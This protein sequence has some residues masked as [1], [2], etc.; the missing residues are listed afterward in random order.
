MRPALPALPI[1]AILPT[2]AMAAPSPMFEMFQ[3]LCLDTQGRSAAVGALTGDWTIVDDL[4][5][6]LLR[7]LG[8][9]FDQV[10]TRTHP[11][12]NDEEYMLVSGLNAADQRR[13]CTLTGRGDQTMGRR[14][15][16]RSAAASRSAT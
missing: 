8:G 10:V 6:P 3:R 1:A 16:A 12:A 7:S 5:A 15:E 2:Q 9:P 13:T 11:A 14:P 4:P